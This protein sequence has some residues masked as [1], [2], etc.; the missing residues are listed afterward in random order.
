MTTP[1]KTTKAARTGH[2]MTADSR[3]LSS[4]R[5]LR[6]GR[7]SLVVSPRTVTVTAILFVGTL[8]LAAFA[9][10]LGRVSVPLDDLLP[11][12]FGLS[13]TRSHNV[14]VRNIRLPLLVAAMAAG[15]ALGVSGTVFQSVSHNALGSPDIIGLT[16]GAA[17]GAISQ[18]VFFQA[19]P[20]QV[21]IGALVGGLGTALTIYLLALKGRVTGEFRLVLVGIG[22]G[23]LMSSLNQVMIVRGD[24]DSAFTANVWISGSL[25]DIKWAQALPVA[26]VTLLVIP[27]V[28]GLAMRATLLEMG[29]D[30]GSQ[31]GIRAEQTRRILMLLAVV[32]AAVATSATGPIAF[33]AL[34][35]PQLARLL[36]RSKTL[37]VFST[38]AMGAFLLIIAHTIT[39]TI[40]VTFTLPIGQVTGLIGGLYLAWMLTRSKQ[41]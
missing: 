23:A 8:L 13:E 28:S 5:V 25:D 35:S 34:S 12:M 10:T 24:V 26:I 15:A 20:V 1:P 6:I 41:I 19:G 37:S 38:A 14:A 4:A 16:T 7:V 18:I 3:I 11:S 32:L 2:C 33:I 27:L 21:T 40:P 39:A 31:L 30:I 17:T 22:V 9:M 36:T 29:D